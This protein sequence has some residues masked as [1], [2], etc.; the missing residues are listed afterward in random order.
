ML[1]LSWFVFVLF[2][3]RLFDS[4]LSPFSL[5]GL[6]PVN[7]GMVRM[8]IEARDR[9]EEAAQQSEGNDVRRGDEDG[10]EALRRGYN[11]GAEGH[12]YVDDRE[13]EGMMQADDDGHHDNM[14]EEE[15]D[16]MELM[17]KSLESGDF[18]GDEGGGP[19]HQP[20]YP[21]H[22]EHQQQHMRLLP[23]TKP[24]GPSPISSSSMPVLR[25]M[26]ASSSSSS[27]SSS[28]LSVPQIKVGVR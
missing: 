12:G 24:S 27:S 3:V 18:A 10:E 28:C 2:V 15:E 6:S 20:I 22:H 19:H 13:E 4:S 1:F 17:G 7:D 9:E 8:M 21:T 25:P 5:P 16:D 23:S 26:S 14:E 11:D